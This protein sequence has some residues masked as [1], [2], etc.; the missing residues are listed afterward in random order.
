MLVTTRKVEKWK[1]TKKKSDPISENG[2]IFEESTRKRHEY[3]HPIEVSVRNF[4]TR[5]RSHKRDRMDPDIFLLDLYLRSTFL[6]FFFLLRR[7]DNAQEARERSEERIEEGKRGCS[8]PNKTDNL[9]ILVDK[10][11]FEVACLLAPPFTANTSLTLHLGLQ[12]RN[13]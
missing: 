10:E 4:D 13:F 2:G 8:I 1:R 9:F 7:R 6:L 12:H 5:P 11:T 3:R